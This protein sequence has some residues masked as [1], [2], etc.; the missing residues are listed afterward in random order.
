MDGEAVREIK[1]LALKTAETVLDDDNK[2]YT[3]AKM[4]RLYDDPRPAAL[5]IQSLTGILDYLESN[6]DGWNL[7]KF[8]IHIVDHETVNLITNVCGE[9]N[10]RNTVL[11]AKREGKDF[12]FEQ[13]IDQELFIIRVR[14]LFEETNDRTTI[15][16]HTA[17]IDSESAIKTTDD[18]VTQNIQ[19]KKGISGALLEAAEVKP[20]VKLKPCRTFSEID[21][22]ESEF[23]FRMR[24][25]RGAVECALFEADNAAWKNEARM[26]IK[27]FLE[28]SGVVIIA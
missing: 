19:I 4:Y 15:L 11:T 5:E 17:K 21:Q 14:S 13:F 8:M 23:L 1:E 27:K 25:N 22:P 24:E 28:P 26:S 12:S 10:K 6:V 7:E 18:G 2:Y 3:A 20:I 9:S 16:H